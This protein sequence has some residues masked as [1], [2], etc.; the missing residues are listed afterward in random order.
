MASIN[1]SAA[2]VDA[3]KFPPDKA[4]RWAGIPLDHDQWIFT[5]NALRR[6]MRSMIEALDSMAGRL[7]SER[8]V[9]AWTAGVIGAWWERHLDHVIDHCEAEEKMYRPL[10]ST[11]FIWPKEVETIHNQ[12]DFVRDKV[13]K[14]VS[15]LSL[16]KA[17][18]SALRNSLFAYEKNMLAH[19]VVEE[20]TILPMMRAYFPPNPEISTLQRQMLENAPDNVMGALIYAMGPDRFRSEFMK[21]RGIP[22]FVWHVAFKGRLAHYESDMVSKVK[23]IKTGVKPEDPPAKKSGWFRSN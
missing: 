9:P 17:S 20:K 15:E 8:N 10:L 5:H 22:F 18:L 11:R 2:A 19:F 14:A 16:D 3:K 12:L 4:E 1:L 23:A 21:E 6:E 7:K 13:S